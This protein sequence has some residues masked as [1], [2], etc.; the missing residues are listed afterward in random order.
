MFPKSFF[1]ASFYAPAY[2]P[3]IGDIVIEPTVAYFPYPIYRRM[4]RA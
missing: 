3:P 2:W 4:R 1:A